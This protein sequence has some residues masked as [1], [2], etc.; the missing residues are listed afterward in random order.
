MIADGVTNRASDLHI[1]PVEGGTLVR[2]SWDISQE[3]G[4]AVI[5]RL[6]GAK[7]GKDMDATLARI[8]Q[9]VT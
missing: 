3:R 5:K 1:E 6:A 8:E 9:L 2:E 4:K 7:T